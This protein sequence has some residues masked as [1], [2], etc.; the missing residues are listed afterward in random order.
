MVSS[1]HLATLPDVSFN[2]D[3][4]KTVHFYEWYDYVYDAVNPDSLLTWSAYIKHH[5]DSILVAIV[6]DSAIEV[7]S[8]ERWAGE[9]T[10]I[11]SVIDTS[12]AIDPSFVF[13]KVKDLVGLRNELGIPKEFV[14]MHNY[15]NPFNPQTTIRYG[16][17]K[18]SNIS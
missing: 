9:D 14:L 3:E 8:I 6:G 18:S 15:P 16:L 12:Q 1:S 2:E 13:V 17:P 7:F 5:P 10:L 11:I 4:Y